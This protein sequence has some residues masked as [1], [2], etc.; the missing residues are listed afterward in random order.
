MIDRRNKVKQYRRAL[1]AAQYSESLMEEI[2]EILSKE[3][4]SFEWYTPPKFIEMARSVLGEIDLDPASNPI[5]QGWIKAGKF[6]TEHDNGLIQ[7]WHGRVW[8]NPP[9]N[10]FTKMFVCRGLELYQAKEVESCIF[11]INRT[12]AHWFTDMVDQFDA[13]CAVR[14]RISFLNPLGE[15]E[16]QPRYYNDFLYLGK[17]VKKFKK[18]FSEVGR[19]M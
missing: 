12:G 7:P 4:P 5:A 1:K 19:I 16:G 14:K 15:L 3:K 10:K 18:I 11:L 17:D 8:C 9:Y 13:I 6:Y 2:G